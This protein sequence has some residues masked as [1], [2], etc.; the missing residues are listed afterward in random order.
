MAPQAH[1]TRRTALVGAFA[2][3]AALAA[4]LPTATRAAVQRQSMADLI[5]AHRSAF[6]AFDAAIDEISRLERARMEHALPAAYAEHDRI[7]HRESR[8]RLR[9]AVCRPTNAAESELKAVYIRTSPP[10]KEGWC[11]DEEAF[12]EQMLEALCEVA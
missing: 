5:D 4:A 11:A 10:F 8:A 12:V 6:E 7:A 2:S 3:S 9:L 1:I